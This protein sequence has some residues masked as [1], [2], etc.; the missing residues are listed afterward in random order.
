MHYL[1]ITQF[2]VKPGHEHQL[3]ELAK[4]YV[5][6]YKQSVPD[7]TWTTFQMI[8]GAQTG[9]AY[10]VVIPMKSLATVDKGLVQ[11]ETF[12]KHMGE[13]SLKK[14]SELAAISIETQMVN[15]FEINPKISYPP[16]EWVKAEPSFWKPKPTASKATTASAQ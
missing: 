8:Y 2:I 5:E 7:A 16:D 15:L 12:E 13:S 11:G 10:L 6:G 9:S 4:M 14:M 3:E 1:E